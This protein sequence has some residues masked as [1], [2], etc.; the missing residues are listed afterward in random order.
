MTYSLQ[1]STKVSPIS[2]IEKWWVFSVIFLTGY[3]FLVPVDVSDLNW[4]VNESLPFWAS[5]ME[6]IHGVYLRDVMFIFYILVFVILFLKRIPVSKYTGVFALLIFSLALVGI[7]SSVINGQGFTDI[8]EAFRLILF[9]LFFV[10]VV[11]WCRLLGALA[12]MRIFLLGVFVANIINLYF[13]FTS[14]WMLMGILPM[15]LGQNGPGGA[16]GFL[17]AFAAIFYLKSERKEDRI[18]AI[19]FTLV[20]VFTLIISFSKLGMLMG[21]LGVFSWVAVLMRNS[22]FKNLMLTGAV[23]VLFFGA[24][25]FWFNTTETGTKVVESA[26]LFYFY[27]FGA[28]GTGLVDQGD[29]G[30]SERIFYYKGVSEIFLNNPIF[31][32]SYSGFSKAIAKT[33]AKE[34]GKLPDDTNND[35]ANPHNV[36]LYYISANGFFGWI[37]TTALYLGFLVIIGYLLQPY[38]FTGLIIWGCVFGASVIHTNT[39]TSFFNTSIMYLPSAVALLIILERKEGL[40]N[41]NQEI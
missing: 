6:I 2:F 21:V 3:E 14:P 12:V 16:M 20:G 18:F 24:L 38:G 28:E 36:F 7:V 37:F 35:G 9:S 25:A 13:T 19:I 40:K 26:E 4:N 32:V 27:K 1:Q 22:S 8:F 11:Y 39:L 29:G 10:C 23:A 34:T 31:G 33:K 15:L 30:D 5:K 17:I 41:L